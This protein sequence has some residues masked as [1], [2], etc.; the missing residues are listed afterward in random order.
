[1]NVEELVLKDSP[2]GVSF[3]DGDWAYDEFVGDAGVRTLDIVA[4]PAETND[5]LA[6][7]SPALPPQMQ[8]GG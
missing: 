6:S 1:M 8:T 2:E 3:V 7:P 4:P 5:P